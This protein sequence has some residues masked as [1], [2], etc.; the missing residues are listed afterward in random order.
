MIRI[1]LVRLFAL[2]AIWALSAAVPAAAQTSEGKSLDEVNKELSNPIS[3][4]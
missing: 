1:R 4:I 3:S 2:V